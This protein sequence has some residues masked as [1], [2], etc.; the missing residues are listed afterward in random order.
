MCF[1]QCFAKCLFTSKF[2]AIF[3]LKLSKCHAFVTE[4]ILLSLSLSSSILHPPNR[5][6]F[7]TYSIHI[8]VCLVYFCIKICNLSHGHK[9]GVHITAAFENDIFPKERKTLHN[10]RISPFI[11]NIEQQL[12]CLVALPVARKKS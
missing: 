12:H 7:S 10:K 8:L 11:N 5:C 6:L 2:M 9:H 3:S 4:N 1:F